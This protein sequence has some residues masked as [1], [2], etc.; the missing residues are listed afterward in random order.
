MFHE[1]LACPFAAV[2]SKLGS[3]NRFVAA[4]SKLIELSNVAT[5]IEE[6]LMG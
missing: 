5:K 2:L 3:A 6:I 4:E 1:S